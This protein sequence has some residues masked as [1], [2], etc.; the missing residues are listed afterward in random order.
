MKFAIVA[1]KKERMIRCCIFLESHFHRCL[2][3]MKHMYLESCVSV[4]SIKFL[5]VLKGFL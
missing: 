5:E 1:P 2:C 3:I 4:F